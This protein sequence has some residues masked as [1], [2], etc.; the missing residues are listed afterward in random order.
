MKELRV[1]AI[2]NG[3][4]IDHIPARNVN[5][6]SKI[7]GLDRYDDMI[8]VGINLD[9]KKLGKKGVI[10]FSNRYLEP[11]EV[12]KISL[13]A[14]MATVVTIKNYEIISKKLV[15]VP[16]E[17]I[18]IAQCPNPKCITNH[19][20]I[21]TKFQIIKKSGL[22]QLCCYYCEKTYSIDEIKI[23]I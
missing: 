16:D 5:K 9:S 21:D 18:G 10:K 7:L 2:E 13:F 17:L 8:L 14:P 22:Y 4:V 1:S 20:K 15:E 6:V 12:N 11:E 19:E 23:I 3:T